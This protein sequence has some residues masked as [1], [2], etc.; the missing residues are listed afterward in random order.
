MPSTEKVPEVR[1]LL[2]PDALVDHFKI[3]R[4]LGRGGMAEVYLA[5]DTKLG[6]KVAL[7]VIRPDA[8]GTPDAVERFLF[9]ARA[10]AKF[11]HP[12]I[13]TIYAV[14]EHQGKPY[15]ALE[16]L[17]GQTLRQRLEQE[18]PSVVE[19]MR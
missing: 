11:N 8:L 15:V 6:R 2:A 12:H 16:F 4:P 3:I 19:T 9:E 7:K 18:R 14:G 17:E 5:R 10:T 1:W 13:V